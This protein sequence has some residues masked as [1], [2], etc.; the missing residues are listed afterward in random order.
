M[1]TH[2]AIADFAAYLEAQGYPP[3][4]AQYVAKDLLQQAMRAY[5]ATGQPHGRSIAGL[6]RWLN[7]M[8]RDER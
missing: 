6:V 1:P 8:R 4:R 3:E 2:P 7:P 5:I